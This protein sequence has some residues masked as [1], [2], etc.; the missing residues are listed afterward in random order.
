MALTAKEALKIAGIEKNG[1]AIPLKHDP[2][3]WRIYTRDYYRDPDTNKRHGTR[4]LYCYIV[5]KKKV[6]IEEYRRI[7]THKGHLRVPGTKVTVPAK[8]SPEDFRQLQDKSSYESDSPQEDVTQTPSKPLATAVE[9]TPAGSTEEAALTTGILQ[10]QLGSVPIYYATAEQIGLVDD[11]TAAYGEEDAKLI[12]SVAM[13]YLIDRDNVGRRYNWFANSYALPHPDAVSDSY[14]CKFYSHL[15]KQAASLS[16]LFALRMERC[17]LTNLIGFDST[18]IAT[19]AQDVFDSKISKT[20]EGEYA[21]M[22]HMGLLFA[23]KVRTP[24]LYVI[25]PGN[26]PD[27]STSEDLL[28]RIEELSGDKKHR[29]CLIEDR[30]YYNLKALK[31]AQLRKIHCLQSATD[32]N[33]GW[34]AEEIDQLK[35]GMWD[36][37]TILTEF[38]LHATTVAVE[39][40][41]DK[42][43]VKLWLHIYRDDLTCATQTKAFCAKLQA[44]ADSWH[45]AD[46]KKREDLMNHREFSFFKA[47]N[48]V[49][50][51]ALERD[52]GAV[53]AVIRYFGYFANVTNYKTDAHSALLAYRQRDTI[54]KCFKYGKGGISLNTLRAH[55]QDTAQGRFVISFVALCI[56]SEIQYQLGLER[57]FD[58]SRKKPLKPNT[59]HLTDIEYITRGVS[60]QYGLKTEEFWISGVLKKCRQLALAC[61][62]E[63]AYD[64]KPNFIKDGHDLLIK[65]ESY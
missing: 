42:D 64:Q 44:F 37:E 57:K 31:E 6:S 39:K 48:G 56:A 1:L 52:N 54:E 12:L 4:Q 35:V 9:T 13:Q 34:I 15:G 29:I 11:L 49:A 47:A 33:K 36:G 53:D 2:F 30:G 43:K 61:G 8:L 14:L 7:Y 65:G 16:K 46:Q 55:R 50:A 18:S 60:I 3:I 40:T 17:T 63:H 26:V 45:D 28:K 27:V 38:G 59:Y 20:K 23:Q 41:V 21:P 19:A 25:F 51:D 22:L 32:V 10:K 58:N 62:C 24:L 5:S